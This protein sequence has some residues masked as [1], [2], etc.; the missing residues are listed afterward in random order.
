MVSFD[1]IFCNSFATFKA[2]KRL[3]FKQGLDK[4]LNKEDN[5]YEIDIKEN[6]DIVIGDFGFIKSSHACKIKISSIYKL[7][8]K[9]REK[10]I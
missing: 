8:I 7:N 2:L 10:L 5:M 4:T 3:A 1:P 9:I 6:Q